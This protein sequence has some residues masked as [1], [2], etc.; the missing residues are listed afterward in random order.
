MTNHV[1]LAPKRKAVAAQPLTARPIDPNGWDVVS[2]VLIRDLNAAIATAKK[3]PQAFRSEPVA[4]AVVEGRFGDWRIAPDG[5][6]RLINLAVPLK[7]VSVSYL[8]NREMLETATAM[9]RVELEYIP[10]GTRMM[11]G[12]N[13][14][15][16]KVE[17]HLLVIRTRPDPMRLM[18]DGDHR[19]AQVL[20]IDGGDVLGTRLKS[21]LKVGLDKWFNENLAAFEHVFATINVAQAVSEDTEG[22]FNWLVPSAVSYAFGHNTLDP[23]R[24]VLAILCQTGGRK[25]DGLIAQAQADMVPDNAT[26]AFCISRPRLV[27]EMIAKSLP[28]SFDGLSAKDLTFSA[29]DT[30][31][32]LARP[33][34]LKNVKDPDSGKTYSPIMQRLAVQVGETE[35]RME[36]ETETEI[37]AGVWSIVNT[38]DKY[39]YA[40]GR[41][42]KGNKILKV[43]RT[44]HD[45]RRQTRQDK[46]AT[47][48]EWV[49]R[50]LAL[51]AGIVAIAAT[52]GVAGVA[53][54][55]AVALSAGVITREAIKL[56]GGTDGP[57]I[58]LLVTNAQQAVTWS[59][60]RRFDPVFVALNGGLQV[61]GISG[62]DGLLGT[63]EDPQVAFQQPFAAVMAARAGRALG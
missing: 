26:S 33:L 12:P 29:K 52:G 45:D 7:D 17:T 35:V 58:D 41:N 53:F 15:E 25:A 3:S 19:V 14:A 57:S 43:E 59:T 54:G 10:S 60:A 49:V 4:E 56:A 39:T 37:T 42:A 44:F 8:G 9:V 24:S 51:V 28:L 27:H 63:A 32:N 55:V 18:A 16:K 31:V 5:S 50:G 1:Q 62:S 47:I 2:A 46:T 30:Q 38:I 61:G 6:G 34:R 36:S 48:L 23:E 11:A 40:L 21:V 13:G 22:G 20:G